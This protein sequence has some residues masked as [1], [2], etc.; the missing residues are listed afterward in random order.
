MRFHYWLVAALLGLGIDAPA[1]AQTPP[2]LAPAALAGHGPKTNLTE[3]LTDVW[4][5]NAESG[6]GIQF[7][8][9]AA[10]VFATMYV[11]SAAGQPTFYVAV[12]DNVPP[13]SPTFSGPLSS[14]TGPYFGGPFNP[15]AVVENV[16]GTMTFQLAGPGVGTLFYNVGPTAVT[17][18]INRQ[19][20]ALE[21]NDGEY[22]FFW[23]GT[24]SSGPC[25]P[26]DLP[27]MGATIAIDQTGTAATISLTGFRDSVVSQCGLFAT[28]S[29]VGRLGRYQGTVACV[30]GRTGQL[31]LS[32]ILNRVD[33]LTGAWDLTWD[34]GCRLLGN[35]AAFEVQM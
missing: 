35:F 25:E 30:S 26:A 28:Y 27:E 9:N 33:M 32:G 4:W 17:K 5:P 24:G 15:A 29:Q 2:A 12:L 18:T 16:V 11:Y 14:T 20:L 8:H 31:I 6:W 23:S 22:S 13:G 34:N 1:V 21:D 3:D 19:P 7:V 10:T